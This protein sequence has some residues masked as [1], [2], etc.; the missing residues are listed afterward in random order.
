MVARFRRLVDWVLTSEKALA[1]WLRAAYHALL[2]EMTTMAAGTALFTILA[3]VPALAAVVAIYGLVA[4][5]NDIHTH[6]R[7]LETVLPLDIVHFL[8]DQLERAAKRSD[9]ELGIAVATSLV[10]ALYSGR[11]AAA[12]LINTLNQAYRVRERRHPVY[13][14]AITVFMAAGAMVGVILVFGASVALPGIVAMIDVQGYGLMSWLR[15]PV[16]M[17]IVLLALA[18]MYR[19]A[20]SPRPLGTERHVFPGSFFATALLMALSWGLSA[21][22]ERVAD[23]ELFYGAFGSVIVIVLWFYLAVIAIVLGGF[24]NAELERGSGAPEPDREMY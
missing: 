3:T 6:L 10:V 23:Y 21:W 20:P 14:I 17:T 18:A 8:Q 9:N 7:G 15:W 11:G 22:V 2:G 13:R 1:R 12:A 5:P 16:L 19:F 24:V 4:D